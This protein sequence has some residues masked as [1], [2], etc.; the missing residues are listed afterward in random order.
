MQL[1]LFFLLF[2]ARSFASDLLQ[3]FQFFVHVLE[4]HLLNGSLRS[5]VA[6]IGRHAGAAYRKLRI[7][8]GIEKAWRYVQVKLLELKELFNIDWHPT[9]H[10]KG[11][12]LFSQLS[13]Q[14][15]LARLD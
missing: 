1:F 13:T 4:H 5:H 10:L 3:K 12:R 15:K 8:W 7:R 6:T 2:L 9:N 14:L 11:E